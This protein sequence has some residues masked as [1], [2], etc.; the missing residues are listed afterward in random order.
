MAWCIDPG[1][2]QQVSAAD[3]L[4]ARHIGQRISFSDEPSR[5]RVELNHDLPLEQRL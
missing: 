1:G 5:R 4:N 2:N 3:G